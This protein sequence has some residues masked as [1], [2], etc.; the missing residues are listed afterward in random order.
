LFAG[1]LGAGLGRGNTSGAALLTKLGGGRYTR[2]TW[3]GAQPP[4]PQMTRT[5]VGRGMVPAPVNG[6]ATSIIADASLHGVAPA[7]IAA[8]ATAA[9]RALD[10]A[11]SLRLRPA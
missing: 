8:A 6:G 3:T 4:L 1:A 7:S 5:S 11:S 9:S 2:D 10:T